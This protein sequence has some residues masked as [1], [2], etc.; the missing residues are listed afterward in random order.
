MRRER[1]GDLLLKAKGASERVRSIRLNTD[2]RSI[3]WN[4]GSGLYR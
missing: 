4:A 3:I 1:I 2:R